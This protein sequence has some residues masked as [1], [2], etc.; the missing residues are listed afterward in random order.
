MVGE[1]KTKPIQSAAKQ[2][3]SA[4]IQPDFIIGRATQPLDEPRKR[5]ISIFA[6]S[7]P[8]T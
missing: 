6:M 5:K 4:G 1:M 3:N 2:L 7:R 8:K